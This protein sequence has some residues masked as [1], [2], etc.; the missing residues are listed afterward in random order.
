MHFRRDWSLDVR[1]YADAAGRAYYWT[2]VDCFGDVGLWLRTHRL[3]ALAVEELT[4]QGLKWQ[5]PY[6][7]AAGY[8]VRVEMITSIAN[9]FPTVFWQGEIFE[10]TLGS[11]GRFAGTKALNG[12]YRQ[13]VGR[14]DAFYHPH[15]TVFGPTI[16]STHAGT[17]FT[18]P[19]WNNF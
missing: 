5:G 10:K 8:E 6:V 2:S 14:F 15:P 16:L 18:W 17:A 3:P 9:N 1:T 11:L 19:E 13:I 7:S 12:S 4:F